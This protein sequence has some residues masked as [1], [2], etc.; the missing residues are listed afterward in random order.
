MRYLYLSVFLLAS[1]LFE[2]QS[3]ENDSPH[4]GV[5]APT[6]LFKYSAAGNLTIPSTVASIRITIVGSNDYSKTDVFLFSENEGQ[7]DSIPVGLVNIQIDG[8]DFAGI[9]LFTASTTVEIKMN[10]VLEPLITLLYTQPI[11][12]SMLSL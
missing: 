3:T 5:F 10:E 9:I 1:C 4:L 8:I 7:I 11:Q 12:F 2:R 6:L